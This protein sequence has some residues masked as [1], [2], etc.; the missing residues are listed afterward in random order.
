MSIRIGKSVVGVRPESSAYTWEAPNATYAFAA[1]D[2]NVSPGGDNFER[3]EAQATFG[4]L[5]PIPGP[6]TM[7]ISFKVS[8]VGFDD[9]PGL[10]PPH[11]DQALRACGLRRESVG[12][13]GTETKWL[14][15]PWSTFGTADTTTEFY[16]AESYS[17]G[18]WFDGIFYQAKG[19][20]GNL[21]I[22]C[23]MGQP[24]E[25]AFN[26]RGA[27]QG[28]I[29][30]AIVTPVGESTLT[31]PTFLGAG[32]D[33]HSY[34]AEI[35]SCTI[36]LG[37]QLANVIDANDANGI[38]GTTI[39]DRRIVGTVNPNMTTTTDHDWF[40]KWRSGALG[41]LTWGPLGGLVTG[42]DQ[43]EM[44]VSNVQ[45]QVP[46]VG[47]RE[48]VQILDLP[49]AV[50]VPPGSSEGDDFTLTFDEVL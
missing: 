26:F 37:N 4:K 11:F 28:M 23:V 44:S 15:K 13:A 36:D 42:D 10:T 40:G 3:R 35:E 17:V 1:Y 46:S 20:H 5:A 49:F 48:S 32:F 34:A 14:Y 38:K 24:V 45:Y 7:E 30:Q 22:S 50:V 33:I 16:P 18:A 19:C 21:V 12:G 47:D 9:Q 2:I 41:T 8:A 27:Y 31:P 29:N 39:A 6:A 25:L 43:I